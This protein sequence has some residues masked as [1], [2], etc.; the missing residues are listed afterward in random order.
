M[1]AGC[2]QG[3]PEDLT[4]LES[5]NASEQTRSNQ[6]RQ[7]QIEKETLLEI[8]QRLTELEDQLVQQKKQEQEHANVYLLQRSQLT[9]EIQSLF[10]FLQNLRITENEISQ[11]ARAYL[12]DRDH[13]A[14][15][16]REQV[17]YEIQALEAEIQQGAQGNS[18]NANTK[19]MSLSEQEDSLQNQNTAQ[20]Q[21]LQ[22]LRAQ[23]VNI[24]T[25]AHLQS[26]DIA[27]QTQQK[28]ESLLEDQA[29]IQNEILQFRQ[30]LLRMENQR[31]QERINTQL[32]TDQ[33]QQERRSFFAQQKKIEEMLKNLS[34]PKSREISKPAEQ[35]EIPNETVVE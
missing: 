12:M 35:P 18:D 5:M 16:A 15:V 30:S 6:E 27:M 13:A 25:E 28:R 31:A 8:R 24:S 11:A 10:A 1:S 2:S 29:A 26:R 23:R 4:L 22:D 3:T 19:T 34:A 32:L 17:D 9:N 33:I 7:I 14:R 20:Q 21:R